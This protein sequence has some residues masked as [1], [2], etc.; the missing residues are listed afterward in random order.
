MIP[1]RHFGREN[2][3]ALSAFA[4][5]SP[6]LSA[7]PARLLLSWWEREIQMWRFPEE[8]DSAESPKRLVAK[9]MI[10]VSQGH[11]IVMLI[12]PGR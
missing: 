1:F 9:I 4:Q 7:P 3:R 11:L 2:P 6:V 5:A 12:I 8:R 10:Q